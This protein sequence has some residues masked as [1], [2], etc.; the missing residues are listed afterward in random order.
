LNFASHRRAHANSIPRI[1]R[2]S[3]IT[4]IAGPGVNTIATPMS[5]TVSPMTRMKSRRIVRQVASKADVVTECCVLGFCVGAT[6][7]SFCIV[8]Q[9]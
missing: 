6:S 2:P 1:A 7:V 9:G 4:K 8:V 5:K 3:G